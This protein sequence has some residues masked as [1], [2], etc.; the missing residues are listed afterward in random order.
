MAEN[1]NHSLEIDVNGL[2]P[3]VAPD[4]ERSGFWPAVGL[5]ALIGALFMAALILFM[6]FGA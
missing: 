4:G 1:L 3:V 2:E 6:N 5:G